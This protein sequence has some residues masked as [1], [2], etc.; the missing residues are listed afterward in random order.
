M[1]RLLLPA[2]VLL[3]AACNQDFDPADRRAAARDEY[4][5]RDQVCEVV[6]RQAVARGTLRSYAD[7]PQ[8]FGVVVRF[9]DGD[10][11]VGRPQNVNH[12]EPIEPGGEWTWEATVDVDDPP[13]DLRCN[14]IQVVIGD[15]VD[16]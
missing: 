13:A 11:D 1:R 3:V 9:F 4:D 16:H 2:A 8:G 6:G 15:D 12:P 7:E 14:V 5:I 10:V